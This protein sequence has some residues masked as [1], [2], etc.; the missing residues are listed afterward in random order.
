MNPNP[1]GPGRAADPGG[2]PGRFGAADVARP[3][4][5]DLDRVWIGVAAQVW[6]REKG[7]LER[8]LARLLRSPGLARALL[9]T[10]S[11][12][13]PWLIAS[14]AVFAAGAAATVGTGTPWVALLAP[15]IAGAGIAY[16]YGPGVD[17]AYELSMSMAV[18]DR[19]VLLARVVAIFAVNAA[20]GLIA[21]AFSSAAAGLAFSWLVPMTAVS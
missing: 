11:L 8:L 14:A 1:P 6:R 5:V 9:S 10:P 16:A 21:S 20:L 18:S 2:T 12:R 7:P 19:M 13:I 3:A 4:D 15:G 17:P